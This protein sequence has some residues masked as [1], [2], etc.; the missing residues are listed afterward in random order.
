MKTYAFFSA[1]YVYFA[2]SSDKDYFW[3]KLN[4][5]APEHKTRY[6]LAYH[7]FPNFQAIV[8]TSKGNGTHWAAYISPTADRQTVLAELIKAAYRLNSKEFANIPIQEF[9]Y[10]VPV[11]EFSSCTMPP[12]P[13]D[14]ELIG[15]PPMSEGKLRERVEYVMNAR[16]KLWFRQPADEDLL[17]ALA[18]QSERPHGTMYLKNMDGATFTAIDLYMVPDREESSLNTI[19]SIYAY[20]LFVAMT[21]LFSQ[22]PHVKEGKTWLWKLQCLDYEHLQNWI[23]MVRQQPSPHTPIFKTS[24]T[25]TPV[26][27]LK[28][29]SSVGRCSTSWV[30]PYPT[31]STRKSPARCQATNILLTL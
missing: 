7:F 10:T 18:P 16:P 11:P 13:T 19:K 1:R 23:S 27:D 12:R 22:H 26:L 8:E 20:I 14:L 2:K 6:G 17:R 25:H 24:H 29:S 9:I 28:N 30:A 3:T 15:A 5:I 21:S 4:Q 31:K